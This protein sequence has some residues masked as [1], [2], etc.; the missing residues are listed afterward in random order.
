[1]KLTELVLKFVVYFVVGHG[2][3]RDLREYLAAR[4]EKNTIDNDLQQTIRENLYRRTVPCKYNSF[5]KRHSTF[6][7]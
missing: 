7:L 2:I 1:M 4:F 6:D 3:N 5:T